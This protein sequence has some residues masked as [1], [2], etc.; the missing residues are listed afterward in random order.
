MSLVEIAGTVALSI[1]ADR[2][3]TAELMRGTSTS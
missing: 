3:E 1:V 2:P